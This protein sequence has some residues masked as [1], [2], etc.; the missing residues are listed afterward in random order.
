MPF[1]LVT[2]ENHPQSDV[3]TH[4]CE[5]VDFPLSENDQAV[6]QALQEKVIAWK[7]VGLAAPQI[8][9]PRKICVV[10]IDD[11]A[12]AIRDD[13]QPFPLTTFINPYYT[14]TKD[15]KVCFDWEGCFSVKETTGK[16]P[17]FDKIQY[18]AQRPDGTVIEDIAT[19]LLARVL[20]HEIDH[21]EGKLIL[22]R[23]TPDCV[24][25]NPSEMMIVRYQELSPEQRQQYRET[26]EKI[27]NQSD[28]DPTYLARLKSA[29][30][31]LDDLE[32][33]RNL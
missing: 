32:N 11:E 20:Q 6:T 22:D 15:A 29:L 26:I 16:V 33:G 13:K 5:T 24:Q 27:I 19:G 2:I 1:D 4:V 21:V 31:I 25:G 10:V 28:P 9:S 8:G 18:R 3:L 12:A 17:R 14:P 7:G 23:L 30:K